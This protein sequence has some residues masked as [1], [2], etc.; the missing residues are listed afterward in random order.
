MG[1]TQVFWTLGRNN[2]IWILGHCDY[3]VEGGPETTATQDL[4]AVL[5]HTRDKGRIWEILQNRLITTWG[6]FRV[7]G[8]GGK[9]SSLK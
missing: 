7:L 8:W 5:N 3:I 2:Q 9:A 6:I 4:T 1:D